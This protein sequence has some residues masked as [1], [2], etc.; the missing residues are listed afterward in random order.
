MK[1]NGLNGIRCFLL[2]PVGL[3]MAWATGNC[4]HADSDQRP[5][6]VNHCELFISPLTNDG[7]LKTNTAHRA[8]PSTSMHHVTGQVLRLCQNKWQLVLSLSSASFGAVSA[9]PLDLFVWCNN[10]RTARGHSSQQRGWWRRWHWWVTLHLE[11]TDKGKKASEESFL[12]H[13]LVS[14]IL[15]FIADD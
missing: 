2:I 8:I 5:N 14:H 9:W 1:L 3:Q 11:I 6:Q 7:T 10:T 12:S 15:F 13:I 4:F